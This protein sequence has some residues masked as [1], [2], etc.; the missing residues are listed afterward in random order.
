[1]K[2]KTKLEVFAAMAF[3][4]YLAVM[5]IMIIGLFVYSR[6]L[7]I[8]YCVIGLI[9]Y[10]LFLIIDTMYIVGGKS[11]SGSKCS[12]DDYVVGAMMLYL[13]IIMIFVYLL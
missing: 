5:P 9:F 1:M 10:S 3:V 11:M 4:L 12:L 2:T 8:F 7:Y 6:G 13:D